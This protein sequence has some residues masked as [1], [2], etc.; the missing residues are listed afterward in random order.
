VVALSGV[1]LQH[2]ADHLLAPFATLSGLITLIVAVTDIN[3]VWLVAGP[4]LLALVDSLAFSGSYGLRIK[5]RLSLLKRARFAGRGFY[6]GW[7]G[8][9]ASTGG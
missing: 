4:L 6:P 1:A 2:L 7:A 8:K 3:P 5:R 9:A